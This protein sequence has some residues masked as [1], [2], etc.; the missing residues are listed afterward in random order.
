[1]IL[2][3]LDQVKPNLEIY[4]LFKAFPVGII[5]GIKNP[6]MKISFTGSY[7]LRNDNPQN[8]I[9]D[10]SDIKLEF[11]LKHYQIENRDFTAGDNIFDLAENETSQAEQ[12]LD[13]IILNVN[14]MKKNR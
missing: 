10:R 8:I 11:D 2:D 12:D 1:M 4:E 7:Q 5:I 9:L 3:L 14:E 6:Y 13:K